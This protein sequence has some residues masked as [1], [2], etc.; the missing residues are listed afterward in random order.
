QAGLEVQVLVALVVPQARALAAD[1]LDAETRVGGDLMVALEQLEAGESHAAGLIL[2]PM[3]ASVKSSSSS[4]CG[5]RPSTMCAKV[6]PPWIASR[7]A[8]SFGRMPPATCGSAA[9]TSS[10][11]VSEITD[12]GSAVSRSQPATSVRKMT[13]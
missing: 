2:V 5:T 6:T 4:E 1:E 13:L 10:A 12:D 8:R 9:S 3:P 7:H 11:A